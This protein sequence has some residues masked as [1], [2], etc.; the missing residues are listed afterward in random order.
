MDGVSRGQAG[1]GRV[2]R[3][4]AGAD[5]VRVRAGVDRVPGGQGGVERAPEGQG[6]MDRAPGDRQRQTEFPG[7]REG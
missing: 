3:T 2:T 4:L 7:D 1:V 5:T 6:G